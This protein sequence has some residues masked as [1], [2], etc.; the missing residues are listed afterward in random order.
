M[1]KTYAGHRRRSQ[2]GQEETSAPWLDGMISACATPDKYA[3]F[4]PNELGIRRAGGSEFLM[5][6]R[7][8]LVRLPARLDEV[9]E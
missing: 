4:S 5:M 1:G 3:S 6:K 8:E 2:T 7:R 9:I